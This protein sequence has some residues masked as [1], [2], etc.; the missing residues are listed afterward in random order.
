MRRGIVMERKLGR[1]P[2]GFANLAPAEN[3][4]QTMALE[5][6]AIHY[7][8]WEKNLAMALEFTEAARQAKSVSPTIARRRER[9]SRKLALAQRR[10]L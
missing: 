4:Y 9:L 5:E 6:L 8:H 2:R 1:G 10:L 7:E 3:P